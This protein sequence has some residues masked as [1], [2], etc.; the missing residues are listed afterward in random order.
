MLLS[1]LSSH[2][3]STPTITY[4]VELAPVF[5]QWMS[6]HAAYN[7]VKVEVVCQGADADWILNF[8]SK[9]SKV[10]IMDFDIQEAEF[11]I[12]K[13]PRVF[14]VFREKLISLHVGTHNDSRVPELI[15]NA[16]QHG[17]FVHM[18]YPRLSGLL[19]AGDAQGAWMCE[20]EVRRCSA[21]VQSQKCKVASPVGPIYI[22]DGLVGCRNLKFW[23]HKEL[24]AEAAGPWKWVQAGYEHFLGPHV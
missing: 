3:C 21:R 12:L 24:D 11:D 23:D 7:D 14:P 20:E 16:K 19:L 18:M 17:F 9:Y 2:R 15:A 6:E 13:D 22:R 1:G 5:C 4:G 10:D 8:M